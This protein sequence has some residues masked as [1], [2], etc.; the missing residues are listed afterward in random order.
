MLRILVS[1]VDYGLFKYPIKSLLLGVKCVF[2]K[3]QDL[4]IKQICMTNF[5]TLEV[6][7][8]NVAFQGLTRALTLTISPAI[9]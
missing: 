8:F 7:D 6:V 3:N 9:N 1:I 2:F 4:Q 5:L